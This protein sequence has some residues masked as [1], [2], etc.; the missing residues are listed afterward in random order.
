MKEIFHGLPAAPGI[1]IGTLYIYRAHR[2]DLETVT[3]ERAADA[4]Q[5]WQQFLTAK[6]EVDAEL[7]VLGNAENTLVAE[8]FTAQRVILQDQTLVSAIRDAIFTEEQSALSATKSA[9]Y[10]LTELFRNLGDEYFAGRSI[11]I[12]DIGQRLLTH[13]GGGSSTLAELQALPPQTI[14]VTMD[15]TPSELTQLPLDHILG[16]ALAESTPTAHSAILARTLGIPMV[17]TLGDGILEL[18]HVTAIL[19]GEAGELLV[20]PTTSELA[21]YQETQQLQVAQHA[22]AVEHAQEAATTQDGV[23]ISVLA[24]INHPDEMAQILDAGADGVGLLR[25][26]YLFQDRPTPPT[27]QEQT[28]IYLA[29]A[30]QLNGRQLTVRALDAGGDKPMRYLHHAPEA[31]PFLGLRGTRLLLARPALLRTQFRALCQA[32]AQLADRAEIRFMLPM[33]SCIEEVRTVRRLLNEVLDEVAAEE[34]ATGSIQ[35]AMKIGTMIEIPSAALTAGPIATLVDFLSI[36]TNDLAQYTLATDR[37]NASVAA[38]ADPLH[39]AVLQLIKQTCEAGDAAGIPVSICG[40]LSGDPHAVPLLLGLGLRELSAPLPAVPVVKE[41][42]RGC[43]LAAGRRMADL[44]LQCADAAEVRRLL[45][46][47][48]T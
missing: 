10:H 12:L 45:T 26:E 43:T 40:E 16:I 25:T 34:A 1:G 19:D 15:L 44:A 7:A 14:L 39:P 13:M 37:T 42:V 41:A 30:E 4:E 18:S 5:E 38:L 29:L 8:V 28:A 3:R 27:Q 36:G 32:A 23:E 31:N 20:V 48:G 6:A 35:P 22:F 2:F 9:I 17:C 33:I 24:N 21:N 47:K 46:A 11:D